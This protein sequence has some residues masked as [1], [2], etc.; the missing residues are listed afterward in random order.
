MQRGAGAARSACVIPLMR[1][2]GVFRFIRRRP[3]GRPRA[4]IGERHLRRGGDA[5]STTAKRSGSA[6]ARARNPSRT[7]RWKAR[8]NSASNRVTSPGALRARPTLDGQVEQERQVRAA[9]RRS[10]RPGARA[11]SSSGT[12]GAV[13]LVGERRVGE[14]GADDRPA[15]SQRRPDDLGH[16][17]APGGVEEER[18]RQRIGRRPAPVRARRTSRSRSPSQVPPGSRVSGRPGRAPRDARRARSAWVV[19]PAPS[20][21]SRVMNQPR[22]GPPRSSHAPSVA[23]A[24]AASGRDHPSRPR[25]RRRSTAQAPGRRTAHSPATD[26]QDGRSEPADRSMPTAAT[27]Q[28]APPMEVFQT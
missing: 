16:E 9:G 28:P 4:A 6:A 18:V 15:R 3:A 24:S 8:S 5:A 14:A 25:A 19:L 2:G 13:A 23:D 27:S 20:G 22:D 12:P 7:R 10:R 26:P 1:I 17:L 21:P 11:G